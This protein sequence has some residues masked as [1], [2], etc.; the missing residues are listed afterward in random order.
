MGSAGRLLS[1]TAPQIQQNPPSLTAP[2]RAGA[3]RGAKRV[4]EGSLLNEG[5]LAKDKKKKIL[6]VFCLKIQP[7]TCFPS[8]GAVPSLAAPGCAARAEPRGSRGHRQRRG[9]RHGVLGAR[10]LQETH[11]GTCGGLGAAASPETCFSLGCF[12]RFPPKVQPARRLTPLGTAG[13]I[14]SLWQLFMLL[15]GNY[16]FA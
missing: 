7:G 8:R 15:S 2:R 12:P 9:A 16:S 10:R 3:G 4:S 11:R 1:A 6:Q 5:L 13:L 14:S